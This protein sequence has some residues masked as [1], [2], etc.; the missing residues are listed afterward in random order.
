LVLKKPSCFVVVCLVGILLTPIRSLGAT[1]RTLRQ[2]AFYSRP[3][4]PLQIK[5]TGE[6]LNK[7]DI[8][9]W[10]NYTTKSEPF[11]SE[12]PQAFRKIPNCSAA[13]ETLADKSGGAGRKRGMGKMNPRP[14]QSAKNDLRENS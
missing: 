7:W 8:L 3:S 11:L 13:V 1:H 9:L 6:H 14:R 2:L 5:T 10:C 12:T 4:I